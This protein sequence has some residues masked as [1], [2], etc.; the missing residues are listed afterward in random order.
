MVWFN[1]TYDTVIPTNCF[2]SVKSMSTFNGNAAGVTVPVAAS[3]AAVGASDD[4]LVVVVD[5]QNLS[6]TVLCK[7]RR[8]RRHPSTH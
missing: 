8:R 1:E 2:L 4:D 7:S 5:H 6:I 3:A